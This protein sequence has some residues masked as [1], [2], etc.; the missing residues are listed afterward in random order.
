MNIFYHIEE[1][2]HF[3]GKSIALVFDNSLHS[4]NAPHKNKNK[5]E[6][7]EVP[8]VMGLNM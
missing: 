8:S 5:S 1:I 7:C 6:R 3:R 2:R 4:T